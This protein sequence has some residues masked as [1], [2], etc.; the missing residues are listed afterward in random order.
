MEREDRPKGKEAE[1][2]DLPFSDAGF[3]SLDSLKLRYL[4]AGFR[5]EVLK[6]QKRGLK[7][8][9]DRARKLSKG[10]LKLGTGLILDRISEG[11]MSLL[12]GAQEG[13][14]KAI[15]RLIEGSPQSM[16][17]PFVT[18]KM[19][20]IL[21]RYKINKGN[22]V[23]T[24]QDVWCG[25]LPNR[26]GGRLHISVESLRRRIMRLMETP[27]NEVLIDLNMRRILRKHRIEVALAENGLSQLIT[28]IEK[29]GHVTKE[30]AC[31]I[32]ESSLPVNKKKLRRVRIRERSGRPRKKIR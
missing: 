3:Y 23:S 24:R 7:V 6:A 15:Q 31:Q 25:V 22:L 20:E 21:H 11:E 13:S 4:I 17:L 18:D 10:D 16:E 8:F 9:W 29:K 28:D 14:I 1:P 2:K 5:Q 19:I 12:E 30:L 26:A 27:I 32:I